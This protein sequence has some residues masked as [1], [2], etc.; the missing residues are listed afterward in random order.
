MS[1]STLTKYQD[2]LLEI[3]VEECCEI[4]LEK[5]KIFRFGIDEESW[6][7]RGQTHRQCLEQE[8]GDLLAMIDLIKES[9]IGITDEGL[10]TAKAKKKE[11]VVKWMT[12][13][14]PEPVV[15][16]SVADVMHKAH[17]LAHSQ[18]NNYKQLTKEKK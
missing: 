15:L 6:H 9:G 4:G 11:K 13:K 8:I 16:G 1:N 2:E 12:H 14:K 10:D 3:L 5:S 7:V 17:E 18:L